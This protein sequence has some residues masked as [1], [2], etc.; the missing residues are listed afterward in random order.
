MKRLSRILIVLLVLSFVA[1]SVPAKPS[2]FQ[3][4][5]N[6]LKQKYKA[7]QLRIPFVFGLLG[8][9]ARL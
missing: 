5:V 6:H 8:L 1:A 7:R 9:G 2:E 3:T 4:V